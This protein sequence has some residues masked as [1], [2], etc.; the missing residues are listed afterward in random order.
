MLKNNL[1]TR[2]FYNE[3]LVGAAILVVAVLA[4]AVTAINASR[5]LAL[6]TERTSLQSGI[7]QDTAEAVRINAETAALLQNVDRVTL[8]LLASSTREANDLI[9]RRTFSWTAFFGLIERTLPLD[10]R[11]VDVSPRAERGV[12]RVRMNVIAREFDD[13]DAFTSALLDTRAFKEVSPTEQRL[14]E[15]GTYGA[16]LEASYFPLATARRAGAPV[17]APREKAARP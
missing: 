1:S 6:S 7:T 15:D 12:F 16:I 4:A 9:A 2:P 11:L 17:E 13:I 3:R 8:T 5:L 14:M 10:V